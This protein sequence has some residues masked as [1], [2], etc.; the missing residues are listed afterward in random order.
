MESLHLTLYITHLI[1][2]I[3]GAIDA[4]YLLLYQLSMYYSRTDLIKR[5]TISST[6]YVINLVKEH[7]ILEVLLR[8]IKLKSLMIILFI[9]NEFFVVV[10]IISFVLVTKKIIIPLT[11]ANA[12]A[13]RKTSRK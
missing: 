13:F 2:Q 9:V 4:N 7:W 3:L 1:H 10:N 5:V 8:G 6:Q 11:C 12:K